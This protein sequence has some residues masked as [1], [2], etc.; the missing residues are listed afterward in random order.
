[1]RVLLLGK[2]PPIQ[3]GTAS[4][5]LSLAVDLARLGH[6][7]VIISNSANV[8]LEMSTHG[9]DLENFL[10]GHLQRAFEVIE[11]AKQVPRHIPYSEAFETRLLG[12]ALDLEWDF[13]LVV[14]YYF[15]P[16]GFAAA[17]AAS[18]MDVPC[19]LFHAGSDLR[20]I[21][22][23]SEFLEAYRSIFRG[24]TIVANSP[25]AKMLL[26]SHFDGSGVR[27]I[28]CA[29]GN[30]IPTYFSASRRA[31]NVRQFVSDRANPFFD[32]QGFEEVAQW[33]EEFLARYGEHKFLIGSYAKLG[34]SKGQALLFAAMSDG[35]ARKL[36]IG[37][38]ILVGG[39]RGA[40][41][42]AVAL[43][44][45][46]NLE[47]YVAICPF[48]HYFEVPVFIKSVDAIYFGENSFEVEDHGSV[49]PLEVLKAGS[50]LITTSE[51]HED[52]AFNE[53]IALRFD[54]R[55]PAQLKNLLDKAVHDANL[56]SAT[57]VR[58]KAYA[59]GALGAGISG[60]CRTIVA[61]SMLQT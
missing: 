9:E 7:G 22:S 43:G 56:V 44:R 60:A 41:R 29:R 45:K 6:T 24:C 17:L 48:V 27:V 8:G 46:H 37:A 23:S 16:Y 31:F 13:D 15:Q 52:R 14:G 35:S 2:M 12:T 33:N 58:A 49:I 51:I 1:M 11:V 4:R 59:E 55:E 19:I 25:K 47:G 38:V 3:G 36:G 40:Y 18:I 39:Y 61:E 20:R 30:R 34:K 53:S 54:P 26:R 50:C 10:L 5:T 42:D 21:C 57:G 28:D 32:S